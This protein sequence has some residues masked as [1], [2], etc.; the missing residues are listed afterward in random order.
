[1]TMMSSRVWTEIRDVLWEWDPITVSEH[2]VEAASEYDDLASSRNG[3]VYLQQQA[4]VSQANL[5]VAAG[6]DAGLAFNTWSQQAAN[7][8]GLLQ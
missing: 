8:S 6:V 3:F 5:G 1:M 2:R 4:S 7:L